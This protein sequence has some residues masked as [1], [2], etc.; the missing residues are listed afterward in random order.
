MLV[1]DLAVGLANLSLRREVLSLVGDKPGQARDVLHLA[2]RSLDDGTDIGQG[3]PHLADKVAG[4]KALLRVPT[5]LSAGIQSAV[6]GQNAV[7]IAFGGQPA[8]GVDDFMGHVGP[9]WS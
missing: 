3:L 4:D 7:G 6:F 1:E 2:A 9:R 5:D 8:F